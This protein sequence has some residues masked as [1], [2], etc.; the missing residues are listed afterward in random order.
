MGNM[1]LYQEMFIGL[2][3]QAMKDDPNLKRVAAFA[4]RLLQVS[5]K[6]YTFVSVMQFT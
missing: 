5:T 6:I 1:Y 2:L 4:K 3:T